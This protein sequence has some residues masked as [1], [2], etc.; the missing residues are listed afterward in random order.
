MGICGEAA[1]LNNDGLL[2]L[3]FAADPDNSGPAF[4][5][6]ALREQG[7]LEHGPARRKGEPLAA[8]AVQRREG[9]RVDGASGSHRRGTKQYRWIHPNHSY[10]SGG[11]LEA[12][13]GLGKRRSGRE[14]HVA[15]RQDRHVRRRKG[16]PVS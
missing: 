4:S 8:F 2:D 14:G 1:D 16:Q 10:K 13:F 6:A 9:C 5:M 3:I 7:V 12:H 15:E 11:A